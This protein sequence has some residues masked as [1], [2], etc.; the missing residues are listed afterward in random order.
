[1]RV[2][3]ARCFTG[4]FFD[5][6]TLTSSYTGSR[7]FANQGSIMTAALADACGLSIYWCIF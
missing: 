2:W 5:I 4:T 6:E 7:Y 1:V 3:L